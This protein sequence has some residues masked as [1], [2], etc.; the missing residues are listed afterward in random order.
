MDKELAGFGWYIKRID[1]ALAREACRNVQS[2]NLTMQQSHLLFVLSDAENHTRTLKELESIF[3]C[4]QSTLSGLVTRL[5][6]KGL[7]EGFTDP[8]DRRIKHVRLT[9]SGA[10]MRQTCHKDILQ[11]EKRMSAG[12]TEEEKQLFL[13]C[14]QKVYENLKDDMDETEHCHN[15]YHNNEGKE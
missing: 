13:Q 3:G 6:K 9:E 14:L 8:R 1:N 15:N 11:S 7:V 12:M 4:A 5:E 10:E 2:H